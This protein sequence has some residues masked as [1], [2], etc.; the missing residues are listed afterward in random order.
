MT[1][2]DPIHDLKQ[3]VTYLHNDLYFIVQL[4]WHILK[5]IYCTNTVGGDK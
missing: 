4:L 3:K 2:Y 5:N 1:Q